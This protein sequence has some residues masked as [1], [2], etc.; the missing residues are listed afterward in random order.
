[1]KRITKLALLLIL[2]MIMISVLNGCSKV[3][4]YQKGIYDNSKAIVKQ[5]DSFF[6]Q[7][8][9]G[10]TGKNESSICFSKFNGME[11]LWSIK[12]EDRGSITINYDV[13][14]DKGDFKFVL[15]TPED[16]IINLFEGSSEG[17][18]EI[19]LGEGKSRIKIVGREAKGKMAIAL[20][21]E[22]DVKI[23][24]VDSD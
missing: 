5:H 15:I 22:G 16:D 14:I 19:E 20:T 4:A 12:A 9:I 7:K 1:M 3:S 6:F 24:K 23:R 11:T 10:N 2:S 13:E 8:R 21:S 18:Q 17:E